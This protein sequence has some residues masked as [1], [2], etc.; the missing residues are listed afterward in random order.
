MGHPMTGIINLDKPPGIS[1][2]AALNRIKRILPRGTKLGHAG[3]LDP[4]A[5]GVLVAL[6][7]RATTLCE[8]FMSLPKQ[9]DATIR[10]GAT[11]ATLDPES[12]EILG[13]EIARPDIHV[14]EA[15]LPGF[16]GWIDQIPPAFSAL[17]INGRRACDR[18]RDGQHVEL[19][20]RKVRVDAI[21]ILAYDFPRLR[22]LIDCGR[23]T[24]IRS[25]ARDIPAALGTTGYLVELRRTAVGPCRIE[26]S[27]E[28]D[29]L[30]ANGPDSH[31]LPL[32]ILDS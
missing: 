6:V 11:T 25:M 15:M 17:K 31:L 9:Y 12:P 19:Q 18:V 28:L 4:F 30:L 8:R 5:T 1:S 20:S 29:R 16:I 2:A 13:P 26:R 3:T 10:L 27:V 14:I 24:Y 21:R 32:S 22:L 23:G 7:G